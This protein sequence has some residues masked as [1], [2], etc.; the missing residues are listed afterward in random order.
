MAGLYT[1]A[2]P[3]LAQLVNQAERQTAREG[4][5]GGLPF[6]AASL[7]CFSVNIKY[8]RYYIYIGEEYRMKP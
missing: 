2:I 3:P 4:V 8:I 1:R 5:C 6:W 7:G